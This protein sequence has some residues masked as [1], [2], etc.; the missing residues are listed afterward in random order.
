MQF[1]VEVNLSK[2]ITPGVLIKAVALFQIAL[3]KVSP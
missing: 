3:L 2:N 1:G